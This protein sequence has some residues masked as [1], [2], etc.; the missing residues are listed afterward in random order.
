MALG[1]Q[2]ENTYWHN[3]D[4]SVTSSILNPKNEQTSPEKYRIK[5]E[6][7]NFPLSGTQGMLF[8]P[9]T[10]TGTR[11]DPLVPHSERIAAIQKGL[12]MSDPDE[13]ARRAGKFMSSR[14]NR[15]MNVPPI[16]KRAAKNAINAYTE[17]LDSSSMP[18]NIIVNHL[19]NDP[20]L[21]VA[22]PNMARGHITGRGGTIRLPL[23]PRR[24]IQIEPEHTVT[25]IVPTGDTTLTP[26]NNPKLQKHADSVD[27]NSEEGARDSVNAAATI[28]PSNNAPY[29]NMRTNINVGKEIRNPNHDWNDPKS[30]YWMP[31]PNWKEFNFKVAP[32]AKDMI[33]EQQQQ[34]SRLDFRDLPVGWSMNVY[35]G[36]GSTK[37]PNIKTKDFS[38]YNGDTDRTWH[39][40]HAVSGQFDT[41]TKT[42]PEKTVYKTE[43]PGVSQSTTVHELGHHMDTRHLGGAF[44]QRKIKPY[45]SDMATEGVADG[46]ADAYS[47]SNN[48]S[49]RM[50]EEG[51]TGTFFKRSGYGTEYKGFSNNTDKALY[52]AVRAHVAANPN[53]TDFNDLPSRESLYEKHFPNSGYVGYAAFEKSNRTN[54]SRLLLGHMYDQHEHVRNT[55]KGLGMEDV[56]KEAHA[57]YKET[58]PNRYRGPEQESLPGM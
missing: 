42:I 39:T 49:R 8:S 23:Q 2:F 29:M 13:Y 12:G 7:G 28:T 52:A 22:N 46:V 3:E 53:P 35:P 41:V 27:W 26:I 58:D 15:T 4:G 11:K 48:V 36:K 6:H 38:V 24:S 50:F 17:A 55:L 14:G 33:D 20:V 25:R 44:D 31:N 5:E 1:P 57:L 51:D 56:G 32:Q 16:G 37:N 10:G 9:E 34:S 45:R 21:A 47:R 54:A 19:A 40:R 18:T 30:S 43:P